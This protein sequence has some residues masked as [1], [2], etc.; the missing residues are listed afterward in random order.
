MWAMRWKWRG[1]FDVI[2]KVGFKQSIHALEDRASVYVLNPQMVIKWE[3][4][5][6]KDAAYPGWRRLGVELKHPMGF[7]DS[8]LILKNILT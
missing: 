4:R 3:P 5:P 1:R 6:V 7:N 2:N 8:L